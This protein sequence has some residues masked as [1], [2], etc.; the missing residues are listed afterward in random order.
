METGPFT[1]STRIPVPT[2]VQN[3]IACLVHKLGSWIEGLR[4]F[5][6][7]FAPLIKLVCTALFPYAKHICA[8]MCPWGGVFRLVMGTPA[9]HWS[10]RGMLPPTRSLPSTA[11]RTVFN[12]CHCEGRNVGISF[13][14]NLYVFI[15]SEMRHLSNMYFLFC[16]LPSLP[17]V[18]FS[19]QCLV[20]YQFCEC[21]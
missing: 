8:V 17:L 20:P 2:A 4:C 13:S 1:R 9:L 12:V 11:E 10:H 7:F 15:M 19:L 6:V 16:K 5:P 18:H 21:L 3:V 14:F